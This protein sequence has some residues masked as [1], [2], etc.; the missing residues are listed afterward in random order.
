MCTFAS[1][2]S[3]KLLIILQHSHSALLTLEPPSS[4]A[5][6]I[7]AQ[8]SSFNLMTWDNLSE[9][10]FSPSDSTFFN[11]DTGE[12]RFK[13]V[14]YAHQPASPPPTEMSIP[15]G[16]FIPLAPAAYKK[17]ISYTSKYFG[18]H[19]PAAWVIILD[20]CVKLQNVIYK[21]FGT[22][23]SHDEFNSHATLFLSE[24]EVLSGGVGQPIEKGTFQSPVILSLILANRNCMHYDWVH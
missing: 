11:H 3:I 2:T 24:L 10:H 6:P 12:L 20:V 7:S 9:D 21:E 19:F 23:K 14:L 18:L 13:S 1:L 17:G 22:A 15:L 8:S 4:A 16:E 5:S